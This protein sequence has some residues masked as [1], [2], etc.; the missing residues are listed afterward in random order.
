MDPEYRIFH[1]IQIIF[2][3][4]QSKL[5]NIVPQFQ[6]VIAISC[7]ILYYIKFS[8]SVCLCVCLSAIGSLTMHTTVMKLL[9]VTQWV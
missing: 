1:K 4:L 7:S 6:K 2:Q 5:T 8:L 9:Q 3:I